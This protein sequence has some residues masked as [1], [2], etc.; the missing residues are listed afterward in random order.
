VKHFFEAVLGK[1]VRWS[2]KSH[3]SQRFLMQ[4]L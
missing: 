2:R 4:L 3:T 1:Q